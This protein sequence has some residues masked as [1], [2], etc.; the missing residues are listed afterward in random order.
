MALLLFSLA[1]YA[2]GYVYDRWSTESL[3]REERA[4]ETEIDQEKEPF[5]SSVTYDTSVPHNFKIVLDRP[6]TPEEGETLQATPVEAVWDFL[7]P[8]G[9]RLIRYP[10]SMNPASPDGWTWHGTSIPP[11]ATV[12]TMNLLSTR[13]SQLSIVGMTPVNISCA[14]STAAT[15]VEFSPQ[16]EA[17]YPGVVVDLREEDPTPYISDEGPDQG[18]P[19]FGHRRIDLGGGLEPGGLRVEALVHGQS[20]EWE[21]RARYRDAR[22]NTDE[23]VL[24]DGDRPF[25][26]EAL[27]DRPQ[28]YWVWGHGFGDSEGNPFLPCHEMPDE[29]GCAHLLGNTS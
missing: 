1:G 27:P 6:L 28:Q 20:C 22:D 2:G 23:V 24:R 15:V 18:L 13:T 7:R 8:L 9:G 14:E 25:F 3:T 16:G 29:A 4:A 19:Y 17:S 26:A 11:D 5:T 12:F 10:A 21:I